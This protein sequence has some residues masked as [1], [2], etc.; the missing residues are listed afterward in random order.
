MRRE[1]TWLF[2][3]KARQV[4]KIKVGAREESGGIRQAVIALSKG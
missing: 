2:C 1:K 4:S 3:A